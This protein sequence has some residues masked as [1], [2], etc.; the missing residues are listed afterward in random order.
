MELMNSKKKEQALAY[1]IGL[2]HE[3]LTENYVFNK[4][5]DDRKMDVL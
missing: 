5:D 1:K 3:G 2:A 4:I